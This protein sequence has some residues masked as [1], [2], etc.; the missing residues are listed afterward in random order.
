MI[1]DIRS[2]G[3]NGGDDE[4]EEDGVTAVFAEEGSID[5]TEFGK[6]HHEYGELE[7]NTKCDQQTKAQGKIF[8]YGG[9]SGEVVGCIADKEFKGRRKNNIVAKGC[10]SQ[11]T[12]G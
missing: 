3:D 10:A 5:D 1:D 12:N 7:N 6:Q 4:G 11:K 2:G 9:E 8:L